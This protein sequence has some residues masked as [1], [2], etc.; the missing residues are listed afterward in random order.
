MRV[1]LTQRT[2]TDASTGEVR[3]CL[4]QR[5]AALLEHW[6]MVPLPLPTAL[7]KPD[8]HVH[9]LQPDAVVLTGGN[10]L[11]ALPQATTASAARDL[12]EARLL[13]W[14]REH[15]VPVVGICRGM[16]LLAHVAGAPLV[17]VA[18]HVGRRHPIR[19]SLNGDGGERFEDVNSY[20][21]FGVR[22][23]DLPSGLE[24][25]AWDESGHVEAFRDRGHAHVGLM[26]HPEREPEPSAWGAS[27]LRELL[28]E[29]A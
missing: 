22:A 28:V 6:E 8:R 19:V 4:D 10:D 7:A 13:A 17:E 16:Q 9:A 26:W 21:R 11:A 3:D 20:H 5:W 14:C 25:F 23:V 15:S 2:A 1:A 24:P 18:G 12:F 27:V 29:R